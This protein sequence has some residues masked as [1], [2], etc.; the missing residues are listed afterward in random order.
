MDSG[1][2]API[3]VALVS[4]R[5]R[6]GSAGGDLFTAHAGIYL[7][8]AFSLFAWNLIERPSSLG[9]PAPRLIIPW[10]VLVL[11]HAAVVAALSLLHDAF[12]PESDP[13]VA[14]LRPRQQVGPG[15]AT[16]G[17]PEPYDPPKA[18]SRFRPAATSLA[19][20]R[21]T[22]SE[23]QPPGW[24]RPVQGLRQAAASIR[25]EDAGGGDSYDAWNPNGHQVASVEERRATGTRQLA[26]WRNGRQPSVNDRQAASPPPRDADTT[27]HDAN[28]RGVVR[29]ITPRT[30]EFDETEWRW[31]EAAATS[32]LARRDTDGGTNGEPKREPPDEDSAPPSLS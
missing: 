31:L 26:R 9:V 29:P 25:H 32:H 22:G 13:P 27:E 20:V 7:L 1:R 30:E 23:A 17:V 4:R 16:P 18:V 12:A 19:D 21:D 8:L 6:S 2:A 5:I 3:D 11:V 28:Q 14:E 15:P 10:G 24:R